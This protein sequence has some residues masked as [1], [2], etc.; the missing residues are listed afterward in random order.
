LPKQAL[1]DLPTSLGPNIPHKFLLVPYNISNIRHYGNNY[2]V[3][4][5]FIVNLKRLVYSMAPWTCYIV[6]I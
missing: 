2:I 6:D 3:S 1:H 5:T 4:L